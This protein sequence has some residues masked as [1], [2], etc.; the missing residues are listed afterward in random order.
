MDFQPQLTS[1][2]KAGVGILSD[3]G[4]RAR[5]LLVAFTNRTGGV[6][7][8]PYDS[9]NLA[10][11]G[12][13]DPDVVEQNRV[14]AAGAV[15][16]DVAQL[17]LCRQ[18]HGVDVMEI[19]DGEAGVVGEADVLVVREPGPVA[20]ILT[21]DCAP[22]VVWGEGG[23]AVLH[24]GWRGLAAG[25]IESG[26]AAVA[27]HTAFIGPCI[28]ACCYEVGPE[29][30]DAFRAGG[31][32]VADERHVDPGAASEAA[33]RKSGVTRIADSTVCTGCDPSYFSYRRD[34]V[35]GRQGAF[36]ALL[37]LNDRSSPGRSC[38][39]QGA[40]FG[41]LGRSKRGEGS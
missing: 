28:R 14:R 15:G 23:A 9:L 6:S 2:V 7:E 17:A 34:G 40:V 21:A 29:V 16:F 8:P 37:K 4:A 27:A 30:V 38:G 18:V 39:P 36:V 32:Q 35:T 5:G 11:R 12:G 26:A 19:T 10:V 25:V 33:L 22:V 24:G 41:T 20:G 1:G 3:E 31:L 13:D